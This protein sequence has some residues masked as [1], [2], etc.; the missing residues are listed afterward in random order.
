MTNFYRDELKR[1]YQC[2]GL[3]NYVFMH[4]DRI[5]ICVSTASDAH[6]GRKNNYK[7]EPEEKILYTLCRVATGLPSATII[8]DARTQDGVIAS[9]SYL[10]TLTNAMPQFLVIRDCYGLLINSLTSIDA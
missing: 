6:P 10:T 4:G 9:N 7:L 1:I 5:H 8:L 2:F 3:E